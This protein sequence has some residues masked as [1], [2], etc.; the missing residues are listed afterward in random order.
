MLWDT[1][2][3]FRDTEEALPE[4][5]DRDEDFPDFFADDWPN[6]GF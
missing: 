6:L 2:L 3:H 1:M 4:W 5:L